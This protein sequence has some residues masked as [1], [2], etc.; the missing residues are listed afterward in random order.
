MEQTAAE[1]FRRHHLAVYR[2]LRRMTGRGDVA[3]DLTQDVFVRVV[4]ALPTYDARDR[5]LPWLFR[6]ARNVFLNHVRSLSRHPEAP[7]APE[8]DWPSDDAHQ[9]LGAALRE[10]LGRLTAPDREVLLLREQGGLSYAE[11]ARACGM[12]DAAVRSRIYR[13]K[14]ALRLELKP[15]LEA[16]RRGASGR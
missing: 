8:A 15:E 9:L 16:V 4:S 10:A 1:L 12:T 6:I 2:H 7:A 11:I 5:E 14:C 3:E 13:A